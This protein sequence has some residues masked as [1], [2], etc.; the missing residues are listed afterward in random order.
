MYRRVAQCITHGDDDVLIRLEH[1]RIGA[2]P[3]LA[4]V[5]AIGLRISETA[6]CVQT[7]D[8]QRDEFLCRCS[9]ITG[10]GEF[11]T[12]IIKLPF[13]RNSVLQVLCVGV[14]GT[15]HNADLTAGLRRD[16][17]CGVAFDVRPGLTVV[18]AVLEPLASGAVH[19]AGAFNVD[20]VNAK[21]PVV[22]LNLCA[23]VV[24][25][26][27]WLRL[28]VP[29]NTQCGGRRFFNTVVVAC[30]AVILHLGKCNS[31]CKLQRRLV[32]ARNGS[33]NLCV[34]SFLEPTV[35]ETVASGRGFHR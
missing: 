22:A 8:F 4:A 1:H 13:L 18:E 21:H 6:A 20:A 12:D 11:G 3:G 25:S 16:D 35:R 30:S 14:V 5:K 27:G 24:S 10:D 32:R 29:E 26:D 23:L 31:S 7:G 9:R 19:S 2:C 34:G 28:G 17:V 33:P 15:D